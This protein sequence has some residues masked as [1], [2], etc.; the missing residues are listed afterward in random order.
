MTKL[1]IFILISISI[2]FTGCASY[3]EGND[4]MHIAGEHPE[5]TPLTGYIDQTYS[6]KHYTLLQFQFG[7]DSHVWKRIKN[8]KLD[9]KTPKGKKAQVVL[10]QDL[11]DWSDAIA[12]KVAVDNYNK[13]IVLGSIA[14]IGALSAIHGSSKGNSSLSKAGISLLSGTVAVQGVDQLITNLDNIQRA[15][16][17]PKGHLLSPISIPAGLVVKR[18]ILLKIDRDDVP[19]T[20]NFEITYENNKKA[21]YELKIKNT[22]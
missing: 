20:I 15:K 1:F 14:S 7:N 19:E 17:L 12:H 9:M 22:Y 11:V 13:S 16:I 10:G 5:N 2:L 18:W 8:V 6:T 3:L 21:L 4:V